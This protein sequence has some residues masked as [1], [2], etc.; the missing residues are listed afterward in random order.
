MPLKPSSTMVFTCTFLY[1][2]KI[3]SPFTENNNV[4][5]FQFSFHIFMPLAKF[6]FIRLQGYLPILRTRSCS[7]LYLFILHPRRPLVLGGRRILI[8]GFI[9]SP[10]TLVV[11]DVAHSLLLEGTGRDFPFTEDETRRHSSLVF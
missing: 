4:I 3:S 9:Q 5:V 2:C 7:H 1:W 11:Y 8:L 10:P 6:W